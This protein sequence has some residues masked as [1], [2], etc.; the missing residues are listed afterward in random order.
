MP[1][2]LHLHLVARCYNGYPLI[3]THRVYVTYTGW[4]LVPSH[5]RGIGDKFLPKVS[6]AQLQSFRRSSA[7]SFLF[8]VL[9]EMWPNPPCGLVSWIFI[10]QSSNLCRFIY[11]FTVFWYMQVSL[12][13]IYQCID[14]KMACYPHRSSFVSHFWCVSL[15]QTHLRNLIFV[16]IESCCL[17]LSSR[18][19]SQQKWY[20]LPTRRLFRENN[21]I[22]ISRK[23]CRPY[24][25]RASGNVRGCTWLQWNCS[26]GDMNFNWF[27]GRA[28]A[29]GA[30]LYG[31][32]RGCVCN[33]YLR[34]VVGRNV[35]RQILYGY[36]GYRG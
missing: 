31:C 7:L 22:N 27:R 28:V 4:P 6:R 15:R 16:K 21:K 36:K 33:M 14:K 30:T 20:S 13:C 18:G 24:V 1:A 35:Y 25:R 9:I 3:L 23:K 8:Y 5:A 34:G 2:I 11:F 26:F 29:K 12:I 17:F 19:I 32:A 10:P